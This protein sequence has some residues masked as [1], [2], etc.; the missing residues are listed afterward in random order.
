MANVP[1]FYR[2]PIIVSDDDSLILTAVP[3]QYANSVPL[4]ASE[5]YSEEVKWAHL[6]DRIATLAAQS[7]QACLIVD[8]RLPKN[9]VWKVS[10]LHS[11]TV[12]IHIDKPEYYTNTPAWIDNLVVTANKCG[13]NCILYMFPILPGVTTLTD[14]LTMIDKYKF[15][16][17][18]QIV[19]GFGIVTDGN[20]VDDWI[21][22][23]RYRI[24]TSYLYKY[25][26][27][28]YCSQEYQDEFLQTVRYYTDNHK[29]SVVPS[30]GFIV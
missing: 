7:A 22:S 2:T 28:W 25:D 1:I 6:T 9:L 10:Y 19:L 27:E 21:I 29:I 23:D 24:D 26:N 11:N 8:R 18:I 15:L 5:H 20:L 16:N 12:V 14:V 4:I 13:I 17:H 30:E 3:I